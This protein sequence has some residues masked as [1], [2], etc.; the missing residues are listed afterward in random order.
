M[1]VTH[2]GIPLIDGSP[3]LAKANTSPVASSAA[4]EIESFVARAVA[5]ASA[6]TLAPAVL[7]LSAF[8]TSWAWETRV[9]V[10]NNSR[11][12]VESTVA[13]PDSALLE[14]AAR[15][16]LAVTS[17]SAKNEAATPRSILAD[18]VNVADPL[19]AAPVNAWD[20]ASA[21]TV[22]A[23][24]KPDDAVWWFAPL[25]DMLPSA[26]SPDEALATLCG[27]AVSEA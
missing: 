9:V 23:A 11:C 22:A 27:A 2:R 20:V 24:V 12:A 5:C 14:T 17:A 1:N 19:N 10:P 25:A 13:E 6:S 7:N 4:D 21:V 26:L 15:A 16:A 3:A 18:P 8:T